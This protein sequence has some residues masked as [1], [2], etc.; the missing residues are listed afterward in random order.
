MG[1]LLPLASALLVATTPPRPCYVPSD[2][3]AGWKRVELPAEAPALVAP[4]NIDQFR[5]GEYVNLREK[6][7]QSVYLGASHRHPGRMAYSFRIPKGTFR[8]ELGFLD[9][10]DGA[11]VDATAYVGSRAYPLL[12]ERRQSGQELTLEW[13][14]ADVDSLVVEVHHHLRGEPVVLHWWV[15]RNVV[16]SQ[17]APLPSGFQTARS[18]Y[19]R[20]PGGMRIQLCDI[21]GQLMTLSRLPEGAPSAVTLTRA[22]SEGPP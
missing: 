15:D 2:Q 20:H 13:N 21:P 12:S 16:L 17:E 6:D 11:K 5:A 7:S 3:T 1:P 4:W 14:V 8:V 22:Q 18:L 19:F 10:L 9:S